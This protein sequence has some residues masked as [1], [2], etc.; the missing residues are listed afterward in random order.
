MFDVW[1]YSFRQKM[2]RLEVALMEYRESLEEGGVKSPED[3][4]RKVAVYR[5]RLESEYGLS[6][7]GKDLSR[8]SKLFP[9]VLYTCQ[10]FYFILF[11]TIFILYFCWIPFV[12]KFLFILFCW[13]IYFTLPSRSKSLSMFTGP[14][15]G[16][17]RSIKF[18]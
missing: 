10:D 16:F 6:D 17:S 12:L 11:N 18:K 1:L 7:S 2:R 13:F 15:C 4:E 14:I 9:F 8:S 3:I 5:K